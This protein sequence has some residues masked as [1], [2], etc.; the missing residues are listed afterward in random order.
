MVNVLNLRKEN[1]RLAVSAH[2]SIKQLLGL[3]DLIFQEFDKGMKQWLQLCLQHEEA[4]AVNY[5]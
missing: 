1:M 3:R 2:L 5:V 4:I